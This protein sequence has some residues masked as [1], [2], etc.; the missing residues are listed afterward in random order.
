[1]GEH[2]N[3]NIKKKPNKSFSTK[4]QRESLKNKQDMVNYIHVHFQNQ[5]PSILN[6]AAKTKT[7]TKCAI[8]EKIVTPKS[9]L[10]HSMQC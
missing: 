8:I 5:E 7:H 4:R 9:R 3:T 10:K 1:M 6:D 2:K